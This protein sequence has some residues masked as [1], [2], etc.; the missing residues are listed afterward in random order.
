MHTPLTFD[1]DA[2]LVRCFGVDKKL[3]DCDWKELAQMRTLREPHVPLPRFDE[4]LHFL[5]S[6]GLEKIWL[7]LDIKVAHNILLGRPQYR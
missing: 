4:L 2:S 7:L 5:T 3:I 6:P 1:Q